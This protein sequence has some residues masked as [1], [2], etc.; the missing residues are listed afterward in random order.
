MSDLIQSIGNNGEIIKDTTALDAI[1]KNPGNTLGKDAFLQ[2]LVCQMQNQDPLNPSTDT[3]YI[4]Q[5]ATFSQLEELQNLSAGVTT[6]QS[7]NM[8]GKYVTVSTTNSTGSTVTKGGYVDYV[9]IKDGKASIGIGDNEYPAENVTAVYDEEYLAGV[10]EGVTKP[11][12]EG[13]TKP[14]TEGAENA[15]GTDNKEEDKDS[16]AA[17]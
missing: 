12:T 4:A 5:L 2:L 3:E 10:L 9:T 7:M 17:N 11:G 15:E 6:M 14:D 1:T 13:T 8:V 16:E